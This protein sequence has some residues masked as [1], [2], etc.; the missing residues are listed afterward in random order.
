MGL[1]AI[2]TEDHIYDEAIAGNYVVLGWGGEVDWSDAAYEDIGA[3]RAK[4]AEVGPADSK[5]SNVS[6]LHPFRSE[7]K[8][9]DIIIVPYGNT[10]FRAIG[11]VTGDYA[12]VANPDG[13]YNHRRQV[14]WLLKLEK[15]LPLCGGFFIS[16]RHQ[17]L[18]QKRQ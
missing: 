11:E 1:G 8:K 13:E 9:G 16:N 5:P 3:V 17:P 6:Q 10:A 2:G 12:F 4:W 14:N 15:P 7:M 18:S